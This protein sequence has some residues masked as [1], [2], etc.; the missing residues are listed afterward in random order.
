MEPVIA[1]LILFSIILTLFLLVTN[2]D[3][4]KL[5]NALQ[6]ATDQGRRHADEAAMLRRTLY[7]TEGALARRDA[8]L[9]VSE[10]RRA[11]AEQGELAAEAEIARLREE[12]DQVREMLASTEGQQS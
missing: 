4:A 11:L 9:T 3:R 5:R 1:A 7:L 10:G 6:L 8:A 12:L 2:T